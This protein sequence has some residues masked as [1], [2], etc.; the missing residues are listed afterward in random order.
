MGHPQISAGYGQKNKDKQI[1]RDDTQKGKAKTGIT[2]D[3]WRHLPHPT[4][5]QRAKNALAGNPT[6]GTRI[7]EG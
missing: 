4:S 1:L 3:S 7:G 2:E 5:P 6:W